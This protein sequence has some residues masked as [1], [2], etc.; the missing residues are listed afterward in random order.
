MNYLN[1]IKQLLKKSTFNLIAIWK[2]L[3]LS[4][5]LNFCKNGSHVEILF[6]FV[7]IGNPK[8]LKGRFMSR[9]FIKLYT[10]LIK[11]LETFNPIKQLLKKSTF[12]P[13]AIWKPLNN[14]FRVHKFSIVSLRI[15]RV[16]LTHW[17]CYI[18]CLAIQI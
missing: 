12:N 18:P 9:K 11:S 14:A 5:L 10:K 16:S 7:S 17:R 2:P 4:F 15:E 1:P 6:G 3:N 8:Y 13:I